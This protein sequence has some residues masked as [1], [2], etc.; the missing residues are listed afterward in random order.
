MITEC[1]FC[2]A[3]LSIEDSNAGQLVQCPTCH[4]DFPAPFPTEAS[5]PLPLPPPSPHLN[6]AAPISAAPNAF[7][8]RMAPIP[9]S[10]PKS[11]DKPILAWVA[12]CIAVV[13]LVLTVVCWFRSVPIDQIR[14]I[15]AKSPEALVKSSVED[16][17]MYTH[18]LSTI[19]SSKHDILKS[20]S[21]D[22]T[23]QKDKLAVVFFSYK[24]GKC[25]QQNVIY[26]IRISEG[27]WYSIPKYTLSEVLEKKGAGSKAAAKTAVAAADEDILSNALEK[28]YSGPLSKYAKWLDGL[29]D[30]IRK[31]EKDSD[32]TSELLE[33]VLQSN[34]D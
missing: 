2:H 5:A 26:C 8:P 32:D 16:Y 23:K 15:A 10:A 31:W 19:L 11:A 21:I 28:K 1:P 34:D 24:I 9:S 3:Q 12:L 33:K 25:E 30:E 22:K 27:K 4:K 13:T 18:P 6:P 7:A 29:E 17:F 20:I 14:P